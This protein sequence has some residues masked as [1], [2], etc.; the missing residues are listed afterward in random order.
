M[1]GTNEAAKTLREIMHS[2]DIWEDELLDAALTWER[3]DANE[4]CRQAV[5]DLAE[6]LSGEPP[7]STDSM[8][9]RP[10]RSA[11]TDTTAL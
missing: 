2:E 9:T 7:S 5:L 4:R 8:P 3:L 6:M 1:A 10:V 11:M